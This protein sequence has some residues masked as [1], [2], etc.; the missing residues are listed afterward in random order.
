MTQSS[1]ENR[2]LC[3]DCERLTLDD[4]PLATASALL[5]NIDE[6]PAPLL[7]ASLP[8]NVVFVPVSKG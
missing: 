6:H 7:V 8:S 2:N 5:R 4:A 1:T 3:L